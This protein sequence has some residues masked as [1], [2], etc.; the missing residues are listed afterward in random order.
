MEAARVGPAEAS[1]TRACACAAAA[2]EAAVVDC[3]PRT[4]YPARARDRTVGSVRTQWLHFFYLLVLRVC[5]VYALRS[6]AF[7]VRSTRRSCPFR[8]ANPR[9]MLHEP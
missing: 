3:R 9:C 6:T 4:G 5:R 2:A 7:F 1:S 8:P